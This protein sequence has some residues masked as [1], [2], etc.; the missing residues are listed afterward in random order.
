MRADAENSTAMRG[1]L[2]DMHLHTSV[3]ATNDG[4]LTSS[5]G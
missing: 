1:L 5:P 2:A 4:L 3:V